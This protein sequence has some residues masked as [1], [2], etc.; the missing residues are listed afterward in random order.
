MRRKQIGPHAR[1]QGFIQEGRACVLAASHRATEQHEHLAWVS[2]HGI[3]PARMPG[4]HV[5]DI[6]LTPF[7]FSIKK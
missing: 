1:E 6:E 2:A 4:S 3:D 7:C 5:Q